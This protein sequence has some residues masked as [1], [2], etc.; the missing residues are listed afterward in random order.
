MTIFRFGSAAPSA[1][2]PYGGYAEAEYQ[3]SNI[4]ILR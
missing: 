4:W 2:I 3:G 1:D